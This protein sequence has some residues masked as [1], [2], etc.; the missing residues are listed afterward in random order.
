[1]PAVTGRPMSASTAPRST[2]SSPEPASRRS[3]TSSPVA[4]DS[5]ETPNS[6]PAASAET[7]TVSTPAVRSSGA[8][9]ACR[10]TASPRDDAGNLIMLGTGQQHWCTVHVADLADFFRR[11]LEDDTA[12]G[13]YVIGNGSTPTLL[14]SRRRRPSR[15][16]PREPS[17]DPTTKLGHGWA[18]TSPE[19]CCSIKAPPRPEPEP[20]S[21]G[22]RLIRTWPTSSVTAA[23]ALDRCPDQ[24][25]D[26][27][28]PG[29]S[30]RRAPRLGR[31]RAGRA[32]S[33]PW[34]RGS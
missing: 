18:T 15:P 8:F 2:S 31:D 20:N 30:R 24:R 33:R 27:L 32:W 34:R 26:R 25:A 19:S 5:A 12:R 22:L 16:A 1:V 4:G 10:T 9:S 28:T 11:V 6:R 7:T 21:T 23:T 13:R 17:P 29:R 3:L 14:N